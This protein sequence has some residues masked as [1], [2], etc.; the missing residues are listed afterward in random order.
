VLVGRGQEAQ[1]IAVLLEGARGVA[2]VV[3]PAGLGK[4]A[5][6]RAVAE[7]DAVW[8]CGLATLRNRSGAALVPVLP[9]VTGDLELDASHLVRRLDGR[10][11]V[12]DDAQW[13][14]PHTRAVVELVAT[15]ARP[16]AT[17]R[18]A[19]PAAPALP[20]RHWTC[21][22][23]GPLQPSDARALARKVNPDLGEEDRQ[24]LLEVADGSPLLIRELA[25]VASPSPNLVSAL[26]S[27]LRRL[28][29]GVRQASVLVAAAETGVD[30]S[31]VPDHLAAPLRQSGL[32]VLVDDRWWPRHALLQESV[33]ELAEP[34]ELCRAHLQLADLLAADD[35]A[36]AARHAARAGNT[37]QAL[38]LAG[39]ALAHACEPAARARATI[40]VADILEHQDPEAS[41]RLRVDA[42]SHLRDHGAFGDVL[43]ALDGR[44]CVETD[45][46]RHGM[47][48]CNL[49]SAHWEH[50]D[51]RQ[52]HDHAVRALALVEG[53]DTE[54]ELLVRAGL[55]MY[56][57]RVHLDG[58]AALDNA[59]AALRIARC[60]GQHVAYARAR[61][62]AALLTSGDPT[63][64]TEIDEAVADAIADGDEVGERLARE[65]RYLHAFVSGDLDTALSDLDAVTDER[66][67]HGRPA[68]GRH[69]GF[70]LLID[71]LNLGDPVAIVEGAVRLLT[72]RP[73][74]AQRIVAVA[75]GA[76]AATG[77]ARPDIAQRL[78]AAVDPADP[79]EELALAW[80][81]AELRWATGRTPTLASGGQLGEIGESTL[82]IHPAS[83]MATVASAW[84]ALEAGTPLPPPPLVG[85]PGFVPAVAETRA[86]RRL[87]AG[88]AAEVVD[89]FDEAATS[90]ASGSDRRGTL[91]C[92][93][94]AAVAADRAGAPDAVERLQRCWQH[95]IDGGTAPVAARAA[96]QL[97]KHGVHTKPFPAAARAP[98]S[99]PET[100]VLRLMAA[101]CSA[102]EIATV[103]GVRTGT[104]GDHLHAAIAHLRL[105]NRAEA[106]AWIVGQP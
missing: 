79:E 10:R 9:D 8:V 35:P 89:A 62:A 99:G 67:L 47:A 85:L 96:L 30:E 32:A 1:T 77:A 40:G 98:L 93:W 43:A 24:A 42:T 88:E 102:T 104:V 39:L 72:E 54:A 36:A 17:W 16:V 57:T 26:L 31:H 68:K 66:V 7:T 18:T 105:R 14:D 6:V 3:G 86:L 69:L 34:D 56:T 29:P 50:G 11:L 2:A 15:T 53:S 101:G 4:T 80:A 5:I 71:L 41:W 28:P 23:M 65:S 74:F 55:A 100:Q 48:H 25:S 49:A 59:R 95:A 33:L 90:W 45:V 60:R 38:T 52:A 51:H 97:R 94:G 84:C 106:M 92:E 78:L 46:E 37:D 44:P 12:L 73:I 20:P 83:V 64:R 82:A 91:R 58:A 87:A 81:H 21:V 76:V 70:H 22:T 75:A 13:A 19:D 63:W 27:R 61:V 103:L